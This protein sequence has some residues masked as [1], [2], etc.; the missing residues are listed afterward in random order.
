M[1]LI[2]ESPFLVCV[3]VC[4]CVCVDARVLVHVCAYH[5]HGIKDIDLIIND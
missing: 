5:V 4:V 1:L 2:K 3:Y